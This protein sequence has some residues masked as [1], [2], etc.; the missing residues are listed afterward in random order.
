MHTYIPNKVIYSFE[1]RMMIQQ[2]GTAMY[3][4]NF[5]EELIIPN[6]L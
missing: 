2:E 4:D 3:F 6:C 1:R 5:Q